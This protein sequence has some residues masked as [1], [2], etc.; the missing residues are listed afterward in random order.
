MQIIKPNTQAGPRIR[1]AKDTI[2]NP[3][4]LM[5][6]NFLTLVSDMLNEAI[7][8]TNTMIDT[9]KQELALI[10]PNHLR[11]CEKNN[12]YYFRWAPQPPV[13]TFSINGDMD[14]VHLLARRAFLENRIAATEI[15]AGK[16]R[17]VLN[18][19][20]SARYEISL[21]NKLSRYAKADLDICRIIFTEEQNEWINAPYSPNP[22]NRE[23]L[24]NHTKGGIPV[25]SKSE[26][27]LGSHLEA[28]GLPFRS[29]DLVTI[30]YDKYSASSQDPEPYRDSYFADFKV[31]NLLGGITVH[32]HLGAFNL[33]KYGDNALR[34]LN[35][36]H[37][38]RVMEIPGREV[39]KQEFTWSFENDLR[40]TS[41]INRL[42]VRMLLPGF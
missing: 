41:D 37:N 34:R 30:N 1:T 14:R 10:E 32:E 6:F 24:S 4:G 33:D 39:S 8:T 3:F 35:D 40:N 25:R 38:F 36:Y 22:Y 13:N 29:D 20:E 15:Q 9:M 23:N 31:P 28:A 17:R 12:R 42:I 27:I 18:S 26:A 21:A 11:V 2:S 5:R 16:L 19:S 7:N